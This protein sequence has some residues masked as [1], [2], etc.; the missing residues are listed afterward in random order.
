MQSDV[1]KRSIWNGRFYQQGAFVLMM[2]VIMVIIVLLNSCKDDEVTLP[3]TFYVEGRH[4]F[5]PCGSQVTLKGVNKM[6][7]FDE[8][9]PEGAGY[10]PEIAKSGANSVR[11]VWQM[12]TSSGNATSIT[13]LEALIQNC[14]KEK[15]IPVVEMHDATCN[16]GGL[17]AVVNF[18]TS[19]SVVALVQKYQHAVIVNIA[20][21]AGDYKVTANDFK[22][23]YK[24]AITQLRNAGINTPLIID[25]PDCGKKLELVVPLAAELIQHDPQHNIML[26]T[27]PYWSKAAGATPQF[28]ADQLQDAVDNNVPLLLGEVSAYGGWPGEGVDETK[29]CSA[30][31]EVDY[32]SIL[33]EAGQHNIGWFLWEWGP[34]NGYYNLDPV[35]L[36]PTIDISTNG[37][38]ASVQNIQPGAPNAWAKDAVITGT[39]S[40]K[41][42]AAKTAYVQNGFVCP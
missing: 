30:E 19:A 13:T 24:S 12:Q 9:D 8:N 34:G 11:I 35:V 3:K 42:T 25:A 18:W 28:I 31:G 17:S 33:N 14:I 23:A 37:T 39:Y 15:M 22:A 20:N 32:A 5:D 41:N 7:V 26:S 40:L 16:L 36:C 21:E 6:S 38:Y 29:S 2:V 1:N 27:H 4:L 10:F